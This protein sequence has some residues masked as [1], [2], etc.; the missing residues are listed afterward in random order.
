MDPAEFVRRCRVL[1][2]EGW[3]KIAP[4]HF[5]VHRTT[6]LRW[7]SGKVPIPG[8]AIAALRGM[9]RERDYSLKRGPDSREIWV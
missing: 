3:Q 1:W 6:I 7:A 9:M 8:P 2:G 4:S 5:Q